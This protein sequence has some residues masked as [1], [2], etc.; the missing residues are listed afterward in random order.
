M[1]KRKA[2]AKPWRIETVRGEP[3]HIGGRTLTPVA[4]IITFG[5]AK[6]TVGSHQ[7]G[8]FGFGFAHV[9]PLAVV[10]ETDGETRTIS[11]RSGSAQAVRGML[12]AAAAVTLVCAVVR[13]LARII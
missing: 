9:T 12:G 5:R 10:E 6:A 2:Q 1:D 11:L 7:S 4:R 8:G 3:Y 13:T